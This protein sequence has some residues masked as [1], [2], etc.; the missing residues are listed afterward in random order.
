MFSS[1]KEGFRHVQHDRFFFIPGD[2]ALVNTKVYK[3]LSDV[4][5]DIVIPTYNGKKGHPVLINKSVAEELL[6]NQE[7]SNL[8][9]F[10]NYKGFTAVPVE[11]EGILIDIDT[12][13]DYLIVKNKMD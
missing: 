4:S 7:F 2:Y 3:I 11:D 12:A 1:V 8:R 9:D 5:G 10:I 6:K 13:E